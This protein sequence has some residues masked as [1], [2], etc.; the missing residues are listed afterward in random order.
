[1]RLCNVT[2]YVSDLDFA[3]DWYKE[4]LGVEIDDKHNNYPTAVDIKQEDNNV[5]LIL[6]KTEKDTDI[7]IWK[8][9]S[10]VAMFEEE[11]L[12]GTMKDLKERGVI[13]LNDEPQ[14]FPDGERIAFKD[15]FGN[16]HEL[17]EKN[18]AEK[19]KD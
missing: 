5:R 15:P 16:I 10:T 1:M 3:I 17:A 2:I 8:E 12:R 9:S 14:W 7:E 13:L 4:V 11:N 18:P 6:H 19:N